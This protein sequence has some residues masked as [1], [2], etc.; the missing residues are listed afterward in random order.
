MMQTS[1]M[2]YETVM[3]VLADRQMK[4][5][6]LLRLYPDGLTNAEIAAM[7]G[8]TINRVTPRILELRKEGIVISNG[9]RYNDNRPNTIWKVNL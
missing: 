4:V 5:Y 7:I 8:W 2:A 6:A 3:P 1:L 9:Y